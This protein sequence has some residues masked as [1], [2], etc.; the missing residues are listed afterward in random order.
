MY[1]V[2][3]DF[4]VIIDITVK[5]VDKIEK[6]RVLKMKTDIYKLSLNITNAKISGEP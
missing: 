4:E 1:S 2:I 3:K 6:S 5:C